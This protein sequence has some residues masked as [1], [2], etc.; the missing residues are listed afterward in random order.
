[1]ESTEDPAYWA[2]SM[3]LSEL[4][5]EVD[6]KN[7]M[8]GISTTCNQKIYNQLEWAAVGLEQGGIHQGSGNG[9]TGSSATLSGNERF[10]GSVLLARERLLERLRRMPH[11]E[12]L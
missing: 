11:S 2:V 1:M 8:A 12:Q 7:V 5:D 6:A 4:K 9:V 3:L 10:P